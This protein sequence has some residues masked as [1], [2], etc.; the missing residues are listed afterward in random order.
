MPRLGFSERG[1][2]VCSCFSVGRQTLIDAIRSQRLS[3]TREIG[4]AL[5]AGTNCG[6]CLPELDALLTEQLR[7]DS[8]AAAS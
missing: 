8:A 3:S 5:R 7:S 1:A 4:A 6:S 2:V